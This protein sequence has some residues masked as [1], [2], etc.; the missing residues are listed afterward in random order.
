MFQQKNG[1]KTLLPYFNRYYFSFLKPRQPWLIVKVKH[2]QSQLY[3]H[4]TCYFIFPQMLFTLPTKFPIMVQFIR[5]TLSGRKNKPK[6][7]QFANKTGAILQELETERRK[8]EKLSTELQQLRK[9][10]EQLIRISQLM[11][12]ELETLKDN[13]DLYRSDAVTLR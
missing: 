9:D 6:V 8:A 4:H 12:E 1:R 10:H 5:K 7:L 3:V 2:L 13:E 11:K